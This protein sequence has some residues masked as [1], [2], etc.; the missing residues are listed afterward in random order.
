MTTPNFVMS[1]RGRKL[2]TFPAINREMS[3]RLSISVIT[4]LVVAVLAGVLPLSSA[5]ADLHVA[6]KPKQYLLIS[7]DGARELE[8][9][10]RSKRLGEATGARF[11]YFISCANLLPRQ[12]SGEYRSPGGHVGKSNIGFAPVEADVRT[13]LAMIWDMASAGHEIANHTCGHFDGNNWSKEDW[14]QEFASFDRIL[15]NAFKDNR[16]G[17]EPPGWPKFVKHGIRGFRAPYL[18]TNAALYKALAKRGFAY[19]AS[20]VEREMTGARMEAGVARFELPL[21]AEGPSRR[22]IVAMDYNLFVRHSGGFE[23]A[24]DSAEFEQRSYEAFR[25]AFDAQYSG[26]R[27]PVQIGFHFALMNGGAYWRAMER[28]VREV[29]VRS[30]VKCTTYSKYLEDHSTPAAKP[31]VQKRSS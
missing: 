22:R 18:S 20:G 14:L 15:T 23:R 6:D 30:D 17:Y 28:L 9:W 21:I 27:E 31:R 16:L 7:F 25:R 10:R 3:T 1:I 4:G 24:S 2:A 5:H 8:Q 29:C 11:T 12:R 26:K 13:R 19:D